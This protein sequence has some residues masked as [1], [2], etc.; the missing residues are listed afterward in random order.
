VQF[1]GS[2]A[3]DSLRPRLYI[4]SSTPADF[5]PETP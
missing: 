3:P 1:Y 2:G 4:T 5:D